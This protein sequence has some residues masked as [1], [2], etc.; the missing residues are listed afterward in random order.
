MK[1][2]RKILIWSVPAAIFGVVAW[3][4]FVLGLRQC[5]CQRE[6]YHFGPTD[7]YV[8]ERTEFVAEITLMSIWLIY[9]LAMTFGVVL[10]N[11]F[12][13]IWFWTLTGIIANRKV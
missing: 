1:I 11:P 6:R 12:G 8:E 13:G 3:A 2:K 10:E 4:V 9:L 5:R 7:R